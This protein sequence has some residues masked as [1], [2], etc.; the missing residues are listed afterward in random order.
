MKDKADQYDPGASREGLNNKIQALSRQRKQLARDKKWEDL[1]KVDAQIAR[2]RQAMAD[3][4][5]FRAS[6]LPQP[7]PNGHFLREFGASDRQLIGGSSDEATITQALSLLNGFVDDYI[8]R[9]R[10]SLLMRNIRQAPTNEQK[11]HDIF[12]SILVREPQ[13]WEMHM[14][15]QEVGE[16]T[17]AYDNIIWAL[18]NTHEFMSWN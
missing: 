1:K 14:L 3:Q 17:K 11:V 2:L 10:N 16:G 7:F 18:L 9:N 8:T 5:H 13:P 4:S 15:L 6:E 12:A